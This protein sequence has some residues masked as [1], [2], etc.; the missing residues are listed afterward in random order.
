MQILNT[1]PEFVRFFQ[2]FLLQLLL[3]ERYEEYQHNSSDYRN[4]RI[5]RSSHFQE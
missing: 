3:H 2:W 5:R 4:Y 1:S